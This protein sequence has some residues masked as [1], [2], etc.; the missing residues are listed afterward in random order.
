MNILLTGGTGF[1]GSMVAQALNEKGHLIK[2][3]GRTQPFKM[4]LPYDVASLEDIT[5]DIVVHAA[6]KA[7]SV[8]HTK[9]EEQA[10][11]DI[12]F[13]GTKN[14]CKAIE[15]NCKLPKAFIFISTVA[16]YGIEEGECITEICPLN[17]RTSYAKSKIQAEHLLQEWC[18]LHNVKL[19]ILRLPLVAGPN[20]PGNLG[21]MITGM[22][23]GRYLS[24]GKADAKKS[25]VWAED[26]ARIIPKLAEVGGIYNLTDGV[27]PSF[28]DLESA[29][30]AAL[31]RRNPPK[32]PLWVAQSL[33]LVGDVLGHSFPIN[34]DK[35]SKI[36]ST[37][38]F[39]DTKARQQLGWEPTPVL[40]KIPE[41][42]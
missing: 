28:G 19:G 32:V 17:G 15:K 4:I 30:S 2:K 33:A 38:T 11:W 1:L 7:H 34:T 26:I 18:D 20:P 5:C 6:G 31:G 22:R 10:F 16:V 29:V 27:H 25:V 9:Q 42:I 8:P 39:D 14:L 13:L 36:I 21:A 41:I 35:L 37:L 3:A 23:S 40:S 24:I 12:N